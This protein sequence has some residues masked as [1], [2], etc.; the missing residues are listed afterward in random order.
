MNRMTRTV[1]RDGAGRASTGGGGPS[2]VSRPIGIREGLEIALRSGGAG[3]WRGDLRSGL[4]ELDAAMEDLY[5]VQPGCFEGTFQAIARRIHPEDRAQRIAAV[6]RALRSRERDCTS[7]HR[8]LLPDGTTRWIRSTA[9]VIRDADGTPT[10]LI[11]IS[12]LADEGHQLETERASA[13]S[14]ALQAD[15]AL[16]SALR[17]LGL[18]GRVG[19]LLD[20]PLRL[21]V[22]LRQV[23]DLV[24]EVLADWCV[25]D[26]IEDAQA[27]RGVVAHRDPALATVASA[28]RRR[29]PS[30]PAGAGDAVP[31]PL[32][33]PDLSQH[34]LEDAVPDPEHR[35]LLQA[36]R[37]PGS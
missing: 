16:G 34:E 7:R 12:L 23:A 29:T 17:R 27:R 28:A 14:A 32:F 13:V 25:I 33:V 5:G 18:L 31:E 6:E 21:K 15:R 2:D 20:Q 36:L 22:A 24:V 1:A 3:T 10:E 35:Q 8:I 9:R 37:H 11:G 4:L 26:L 19:D 30:P